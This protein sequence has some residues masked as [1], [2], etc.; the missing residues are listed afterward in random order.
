ME[1]NIVE[2]CQKIL[3][4]NLTPK[5]FVQVQ[6]LEKEYDIKDICYW[7]YMAKFKDHPLD[8]ARAC[9]ITKCKKKSESSGSKWLDELKKEL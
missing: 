4:R 1:I 6:D 5:E 7:V 3:E 2:Q 8:Y 9:V